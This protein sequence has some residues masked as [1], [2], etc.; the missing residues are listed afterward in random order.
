M[1]M[2]MQQLSIVGF[3]GAT[4]SMNLIF[5]DKPVVMIFGENGTGKSTIVDA[6]DF[7]C[8]ECAGPLEGRQSTPVKEY[9]PSL[10][11][12]ATD[13]KV[14][15][16]WVSKTWKA[17]LEGSKAKVTGT[18]PRPRARI[19]RRTQILEIVDAQPA[20]RY[21]AFG[22]FVAVPKVEQS[23][24]ALREAVRTVKVDFDASARSL[25][26]AQVALKKLQTEAG[27]TA[28][29]LMKW[30]KGRNDVDPK[31]LTARS[32]HITNLLSSVQTARVGLNGLNQIRGQAQDDAN[33]VQSLT[34]DLQAAEEASAEAK[35]D[36]LK[37]LDTA[38][39]YLTDHEEQDDCPLCEQPINRAELIVRLAARKESGAAVLGA[40]AKLEAAKKLEDR[41]QTLVK[42][43]QTRFL[44]SAA[45]MAKEFR[46]SQSPAVTTKTINWNDFALVQDAVSEEEA[47]QAEVQAQNLLTACEKCDAELQAEKLTLSSEL[48]ALRAIKLQYG[49]VMKFGKQAK[50]QQSLSTRLQSVLD[51]VEAQRKAYVDEVL[52][53]ITKRVDTLYA[54]LHPGEKLG[55]IKLQLDPNKRGSLNVSSRFESKKDV[56]P[57]AYYSEAHMDTLGICI[58]IALAERDAA[59][60]T[61][62]VLDDVLTSAD[63]PHVDRFISV[64]HEELKMPI[65]IT[66]HYRP[67]R[68]RYRYSKGPIGNVHL[69]ELLA[70]SQERGVRHT[71]TRLEIDE[72]KMLMAAEPIDRQALASKAGVL[73]EAALRELCLLYK[74]KMPLD[75]EGR[76]TLGEYLNGLDS[77][78]RKLMKSVAN[79][80]AT[81]A[82]SPMQTSVDIQP[83]LEAIDSMAWIRNLVGAHFNLEGMDLSDTQITQLGKATCTLLDA[84]VCLSCGELP[85]KNT[86]SFFS[87]GCKARELHPL[88]SPGAQAAQ[89]G[90]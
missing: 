18:S 5:E 66:T 33:S 39:D 21:E 7:V 78:L 54:K 90:N 48:E 44:K 74:C 49:S 36:L 60:D 31:D 79:T 85:R 38:A 68:D 24:N 19:L 37:L 53:S 55:D 9:L 84:L 4:K 1:K 81:T 8:N 41:R 88:T 34:I 59:A 46:Q 15:L 76:H 80:Q 29:D 6:I 20:K 65:L 14:E 63:Q 40:S 58:F 43:A 30:A 72:L 11:C 75:A 47:Q 69:I 25:S 73:L 77:K 27:A 64:V 70:W 45:A 32:Q 71:K 23:E 56:P 83:L 61:L 82:T 57:Q 67:W 3:R 13:L 42:D 28:T 51:I 22:R 52:G 35:S 12:K 86:G 87:C 17:I 26:E 50:E 62:L 10:G 89:T 2:P 16:K